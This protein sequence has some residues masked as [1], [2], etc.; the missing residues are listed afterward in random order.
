MHVP[1]HRVMEAF[2]LYR[3]L[4]HK[5]RG[6]VMGDHSCNRYSPF[7]HRLGILGSGRPVL[8]KDSCG[9]QLKNMMVAVFGIHEHVR[10]WYMK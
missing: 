7:T 6:Q 9:D 10:A 4:A 1:L 5:R 3:R 2:N 8:K